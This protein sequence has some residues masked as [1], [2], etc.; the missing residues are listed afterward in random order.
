MLTTTAPYARIVATDPLT[1]CLFQSEPEKNS[2]IAA[3]LFLISKISQTHLVF[4][5][6]PSEDG[7][8]R[9]S[10][11]KPLPKSF[12][13]D[14]ALN[15]PIKEPN[16]T[17]LKWAERY[18]SFVRETLDNQNEINDKSQEESNNQQ[19]QIL[20][21]T[22]SSD[23]THNSTNSSLEK[24]DNTL[25]TKEP[26]DYDDGDTVLVNSPTESNV[27]PSAGYSCTIS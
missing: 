20:K 22:I 18:I 13:W 14:N 19:E 5:N 1:G 21:T 27:Q 16:A 11:L 23:P 24:T 17:A 26:D 8:A 2:I 9:S 7:S 6:S 10:L 3:K 4:S 12:K 15:K 25:E